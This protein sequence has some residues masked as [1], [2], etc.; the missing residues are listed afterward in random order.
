MRAPCAVSGFGAA[1]AIGEGC[2]CALPG[3]DMADTPVSLLIV[4]DDGALCEW[5]S[6]AAAARGYRGMC[7]KSLAD[8]EA[9]LAGGAFDAAVVDL[10]VGAESG[11]DVMRLLK[12]RAPDTEI[13]V[14]SASTSLA[15]AI[16]SYDM[17]AFAFVQKPFA[18][19]Q[20]FSTLERALERRRMNLDN[21]RLV[22]ELQ[23]INEIADGIARSLELKDVLS[24]ALERL[25]RALGLCGGVHPPQ[26]RADRPI[27][28][29]GH[30]RPRGRQS[31]LGGPARRC[32]GRA[33][34]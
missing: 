6:P 23:T 12:E 11:F 34:R 19:E 7:A 20:L 2:P 10:G 26:G 9:A 14:V 8:T 4:E 30:R 16:Q 27:R 1:I 33:T 21:Q 3:P 24:G 15:S 17:A 18:E 32:P 31:V 22:W 25:V 28:R 13:I 5:L 29:A